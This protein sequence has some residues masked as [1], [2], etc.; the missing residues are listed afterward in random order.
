[1]EH[2]VFC[3]LFLTFLIVIQ[4]NTTF[5]ESLTWTQRN[6]TRFRSDIRVGGETPQSIDTQYIFYILWIIVGIPSTG[7]NYNLSEESVFSNQNRFQ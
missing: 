3:I 6:V 1:M 4:L 2:S 7:R 5:P